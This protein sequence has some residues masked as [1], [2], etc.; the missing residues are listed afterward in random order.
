MA[1]SDGQEKTEE[2]TAKRLQDAREK[3]QLPRSRELVT[4][5][6]LLASG[7]LFLGAGEAM[8]RGLLA[9]LHDSFV[10][11]RNDVFDS[12]GLL[13]RFLDAVVEALQ[14]IAPLMGVMVVVAV[15]GNIVLSGW[16]VST[17]AMELKL[18][19]LDP[20]KGMKKLFSWRGLVEMLKGLA[21]FVLISVVILLWLSAYSGE[22][23]ALAHEP[24]P[25]ALAHA[26]ELIIWA[27][28]VASVTLV[29]VVVVDVPF[30]L[31][32]HKR[33]LR[34]SKQEIKEESKQTL[35]SPEIKARQRQLQMEAA[36]RRMMEEV[37]KAD[38]VITNP[39]HYAVAL[40]YE[41]GGNDAPQVVA[42]GADLVAGKIRTIATEHGVPV[43]SAPP[44][45]RAIYHSTE[46]GEA[47]PAGLYRAVAQVLAYVYH[48]RQ[49]PI[50]NDSGVDPLADLPIPEDLRR[51]D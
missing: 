34:M 30:Q 41:Q 39:T 49:G 12:N 38:V 11:S 4:F 46:L 6:A 3:G 21:K 32:D 28:L 42:K 35:G 9:L 15:L 20:I 24:L 18:D 36:Q 40:R 50:Y 7:L 10:L 31:W 29:L 2:P 22:F 23:L 37:P 14:I 8:L 26:G 44:L 43:L 17:K 48:L 47:I 51:D 19:K 45:A 27:F 16:N 33:Q 25:Q 5:L 1:E 13:T